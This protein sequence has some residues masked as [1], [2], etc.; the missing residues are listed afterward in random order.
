ME[1][2]ITVEQ[3]SNVPS[4]L[5][6]EQPQRNLEKAKAARRLLWK[7]DLRIMPLI[8][9]MYFFS[10]MDRSDI[11]NAK[12]AGLDT[13]LNL[14]PVGYSAAVSVFYA[15]YIAFQPVAT[16]S[17]RRLTPKVILGGC[18]ALWGLLTILLMTVTSL[19]GLCV[20]RVFIGACE[21]GTQ[22][23]TIYLALWYT[24]KEYATRGAIWFSM[25]AIASAFTGLVAYGIQTNVVSSEYSSWQLL[26][27][28]EGCLPLA[29]GI[30][31]FFAL[32]AVPEKVGWGFTKEE[33]ELAIERTIAAKNTPNVGVNWHGIGQSFKE[34][35]LYV[36][37]V[38]YFVVLWASS[39]FSNF[40][41]AILNGFGY[42]RE[43]AQLMTVPTAAIQF[44]S[45]LFFGFLSDRKQLRG[46]LIIIV[47]IFQIIGY[48]ILIAVPNGTNVRFAA[49]CII[50]IG[51]SS[52]IPLV[53]TWA[54]TSMVGYSQRAIVLALVNMSGQL[55]SFISSYAYVNPPLY[56]AGNI[57]VLVLL[58]FMIVLVIAYDIV[59]IRINR[60]K[61]AESNSEL[62]NAAR[63]KTFDELGTKHP[64]FYFT[65]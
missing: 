50:A 4:A 12:L 26:F 56:L 8:A 45:I 2:K 62:A 21:A 1:E 43:K 19:A 30:F 39:S 61:R 40:L 16:L 36:I 14:S 3:L 57:S 18:V 42:S 10:S 54:A 24:H 35:Q 6:L 20:L 31:L 25:S 58:V 47:A 5:D 11:A 46:P 48:I 9:I 44:V 64:D 13:S 15:G 34:P 37:C 17:M 38:I 22:A 28:I 7:I 53:I 32:P 52:N 59:I 27:L 65:L 60:R 23:A 29:F 55:A 41:P 33:K 51:S 63:T 49:V